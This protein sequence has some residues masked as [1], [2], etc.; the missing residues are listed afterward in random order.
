[1]PPLP[2]LMPAAI[3]LP[4]RY[5]AAPLP[6]M[7]RYATRQRYAIADTPLRRRHA[8]HMPATLLYN[9]PWRY[10]DITAAS[11]ILLPCRR[12]VA[13]AVTMISCLSWIRRC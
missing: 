2:P 6:L 8:A 5:V 4:P 3:T 13:A 1:M 7:L 9:M 10:F 12:H 11:L